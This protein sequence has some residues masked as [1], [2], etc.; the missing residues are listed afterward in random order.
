MACSPSSVAHNEISMRPGAACRSTGS[1]GPPKSVTSK[2][3]LLLTCTLCLMGVCQWESCPPVWMWLSWTKC[4]SNL[5]LTWPG[6]QGSGNQLLV[7][8]ATCI[9]QT[10]LSYHVSDARACIRSGDVCIFCAAWLR[11]CVTRDESSHV[12]QCCV[13]TQVWIGLAFQHVL[14]WPPLA[15]AVLCAL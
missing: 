2:L 5:G 3:L 12:L 15:A 10:V 9:T 6:R 1:G 14:F 13:S 8:I 7:C 4:C 11:A